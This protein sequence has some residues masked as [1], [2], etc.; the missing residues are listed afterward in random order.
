MQQRYPAGMEL[1]DLILLKH[2]FGGA[3]Y[4]ANPT[5]RE[6]IKGR[7]RG[8]T[9]VGIALFRIVNITADF[10]FPFFHRYLQSES[11]F[12]EDIPSD[13]KND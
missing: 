6:F 8:D 7:V 2:I 12:K 3:A 13:D 5:V 9:S 1:S 4:R 10:A 11:K